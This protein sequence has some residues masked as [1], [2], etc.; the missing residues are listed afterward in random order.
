MK[1]FALA[2]ATIALAGLPAQAQIV[3][4]GGGTGGGS[5]SGW[6]GS[7]P[8]SVTGA[9]SGGIP[10]FVSATSMAS[11]GLLT[12]NAIMIGGG[13]GV[14][15][16]T[17]TTGANVL[18]VLGVAVNASGG[19]VSP[20]PA[21]AGDIIF[22]N[23]TAWAKLSGN[24]GSIRILQED[25]SGVPTWVTSA[26][27]GVSSITTACPSTGPST[28]AVTITSGLAV[29]NKTGS[30]TSTSADCG[31]TIPFSLSAAATLT[32]PAPV[33]GFFLAQVVNCGSTTS[34]DPSCPAASIVPLTIAPA[35]GHI[36][37]LSSE[38]FPPGTSKGIWTNGTDYFTTNGGTSQFSPGY[39]VGPWYLPANYGAIN[40]GGG[41]INT[42]SVYCTPAWINDIGAVIGGGSGTIGSLGARISTLGTS[43]I[44]LGIYA[45]DFTVAPYRPGALLGHTSD[46]VDTAAGAVSAA[47]TSGAVV[48]AGLYWMCAEANDNTVR[49]QSLP[50]SSTAGSF[51]AAAVGDTSVGNILSGSFLGTVLTV[52]GT[53]GTWPAS[54]HGNSFTTNSQSSVVAFQFTSIP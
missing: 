32:L 52:V 28:G 35:S 2:L 34:G 12:A 38:S 25:A 9:T 8:A 7:L 14:C 29:V 5:G 4:P 51:Y 19:I 50:V 30:Y 49:I 11:S 48:S 46:I 20:T 54:L 26:A 18:G 3:L 21:A 27:A 44:Q 42:N 10:C 1:K 6:N 40:G 23:G 45:N 53:Y 31:A 15:P 39:T 36:D 41:S 37:G 22:W 43:N 16:T 33:A 47:L 24:S 13:V 17:T